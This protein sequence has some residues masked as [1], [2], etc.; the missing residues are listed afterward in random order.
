VVAA[1]QEAQFARQGVGARVK[2]CRRKFE[3][4]VAAAAFAAQAIVLQQRQRW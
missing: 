2:L 3:G 1:E 4:A